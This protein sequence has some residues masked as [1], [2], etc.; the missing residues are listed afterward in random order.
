MDAT[1]LRHAGEASD[2]LCEEQETGNSPGVYSR[3]VCGGRPRCH[4]D[5]ALP[6]GCRFPRDGLGGL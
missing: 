1:V 4:Q 5:H 2:S 3:P 6:T